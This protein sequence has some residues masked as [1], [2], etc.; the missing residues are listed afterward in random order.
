V[1][2]VERFVESR[3][4]LHLALAYTLAPHMRAFILARQARR[5]LRDRRPEQRRADQFKYHHLQAMVAVGSERTV[6]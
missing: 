4:G 3:D 6:L 5:D 2:G 1:R